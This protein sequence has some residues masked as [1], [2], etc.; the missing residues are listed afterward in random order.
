MK[1]PDGAPLTPIPEI[2]ATGLVFAEFWYATLKK[3]DD[4]AQRRLV[5][6]TPRRN[7]EDGVS[8]DA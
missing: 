4:H 6:L 7:H 2:T 3:G 5:G 8:R 1:H